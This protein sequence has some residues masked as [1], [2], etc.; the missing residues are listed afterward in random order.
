MEPVQSPRATSALEEAVAELQDA[1]EGSESET[2][3]VEDAE[4][5]EPQLVPC[6]TA[7]KGMQLDR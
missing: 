3:A 1:H 6:K 2:G 5:V 7:T 4:M